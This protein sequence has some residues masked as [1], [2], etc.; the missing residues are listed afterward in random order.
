MLNVCKLYIVK[1]YFFC[2]ISITLP[3]GHAGMLISAAFHDRLGGTRNDVFN[4][5]FLL[6]VQHHAVLHNCVKMTF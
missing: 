1:Y 5:L 6:F 4:T 2:G 3:C